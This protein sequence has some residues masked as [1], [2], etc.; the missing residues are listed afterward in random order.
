VGGHHATHPT[1]SHRWHYCHPR[2]RSAGLW[3]DS[4][5]R[6]LTACPH[7]YPYQYAYT[8]TNCNTLVHPYADG[9]TFEDFDQSANSSAGS[10][11]D[12]SAAHGHPVRAD[13]HT[14]TATNCNTGPHRTSD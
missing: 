2:R 4:A 3:P 6:I 8:Y 11:R 13:E 5:R 10:H 9:E 1:H 14:Y 12:H 7:R